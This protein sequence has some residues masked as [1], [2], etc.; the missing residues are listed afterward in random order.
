VLR[1]GRAL[2]PAVGSEDRQEDEDD[3][4]DVH[5]HEDGREDDRELEQF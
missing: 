5:R 3:G 1:R 4:D 2:R